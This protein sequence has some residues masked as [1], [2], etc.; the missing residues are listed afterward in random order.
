MKSCL[1]PKKDLLRK[2]KINRKTELRNRQTKALR[3]TRANSNP[4]AKRG[5]SNNFSSL[6]LPFRRFASKSLYLSAIFYAVS[7]RANIVPPLAK[8]VESGFY[9]SHAQ[10]RARRRIPT[11]LSVHITTD[12]KN[13]ARFLRYKFPKSSLLN[14]QPR[15]GAVR[16][17]P[18][19]C[20]LPPVCKYVQHFPLTNRLNVPVRGVSAKTSASAPRP[21]LP[22]LRRIDKAYTFSLTATGHNRVNP[23]AVLQYPR[24]VY[25]VWCVKSKPRAHIKSVGFVFPLCA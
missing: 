1:Y 2:R 5:S 20:V 23:R 21:I 16:P 15:I 17:F 12:R 8:I 10:V 9:I 7:S 25:V 11:P 14:S 3:Q 6:S 19:P 13:G 22:L 18:A 24:K 4:P